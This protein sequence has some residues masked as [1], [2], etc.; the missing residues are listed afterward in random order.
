[1]T[2]NNLLGDYS[3]RI[4]RATEHVALLYCLILESE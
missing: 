2:N 3:V 4:N 1:M